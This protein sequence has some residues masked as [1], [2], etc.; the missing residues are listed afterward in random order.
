MTMYYNKSLEFEKKLDDTIEI[1]F[2]NSN[3]EGLIESDPDKAKE[4]V[5]KEELKS[6]EFRE[7]IEKI[8][9]FI[10]RNKFNINSD[11]KKIMKLLK[12]TNSPIVENSLGI[13][14]VSVVQK[15][16][17]RRKYFSSLDDNYYIGIKLETYNNI[18]YSY[19]RFMQKKEVINHNKVIAD[20]NPDYK[21]EYE[22]E[23]NA[24]TYYV[25]KN[26]LSELD[27]LEK[28]IDIRG[29]KAIIEEYPKLGGIIN[30][31]EEIR[32]EVDQWIA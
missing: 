8:N 7:N 21:N 22:R 20:K 12:K 18:N 6:P 14:I 9:K 28:D 1:F 4:G 3:N 15:V 27:L 16:C 11:M 2:R 29:E 17:E 25:K 30:K 32:K 26:L 10:K 13:C 23:V 31:I 5:L 19:K 24:L